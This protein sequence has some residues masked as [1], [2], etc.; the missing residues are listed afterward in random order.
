MSIKKKLQHY[1]NKAIEWARPYLTWRMAPFLLAAWLLT[2]GWAYAFVIIG[3]RLGATWM[4]VAGS[5]WISFLWFPF[6][7]EKVAT[8]F[9]AGLLYRLFYRRRFECESSNKRQG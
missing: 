6:T 9:I 2:N 5:V 3:S 4:V 1:F 8:V 7:L